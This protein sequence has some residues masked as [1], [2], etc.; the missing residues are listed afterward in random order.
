MAGCDYIEL[1]TSEEYIT[2][3][4]GSA[5]PLAAEWCTQEYDVLAVMNIMTSETDMA[6][7]NV[8]LRWDS[9]VIPEEMA[10]VQAWLRLHVLATA[11]SESSE[12]E[13]RILSADW[14]DP[15]GTYC[16]ED[17]FDASAGDALSIE[18]EYDTQCDLGNVV[19]LTDNDFAVDAAGA[20]IL[21]SGAALRLSLP[22][23]DSS[24]ANYLAIAGSAGAL[25]GPRLVVLACEPR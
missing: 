20:N 8:V 1:P 6:A 13:D 23:G 2:Y 18:G 9:S 14:Y 24:L 5:A 21:P 25:P 16:D 10:P 4:A 12:P 22:N 17:D 15:Q 19:P 11:V 7:S 3:A